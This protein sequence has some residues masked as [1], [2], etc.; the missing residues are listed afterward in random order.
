MRCLDAT[1]IIDHLAG[2]TAAVERMAAWTAAGERLAV[3]SPVVAEVLLGAYYKGGAALREA[4]GFLDTLDVLPVDGA[5]AAEAGRMGAE[6]RR[7]GVASSLVDLLI[8]ATSKLN[9]GILVTR[10]QGFGQIPGLSV[11]TY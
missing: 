4:L 10:D 5:T 6:Q 7:R 11:E 2:E 8:A 9:Q 1:F 3:P